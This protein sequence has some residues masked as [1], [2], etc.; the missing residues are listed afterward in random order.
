MRNILFISALLFLGCNSPTKKPIQKKNTTSQIDSTAID[1]LKLTPKTWSLYKIGGHHLGQITD[2][3]TW[4]SEGCWSPDCLFLRSDSIFIYHFSDSY[5]YNIGY[6]G[7]YEITNDS[8]ILNFS[9]LKRYYVWEE[10]PNANATR[11]YVQDSIVNSK[12]LKFKIDTSSN[13][14]Q[15]ITGDT[16]G[17]NVSTFEKEFK[18]LNSVNL[19]LDFKRDKTID[20]IFENSEYSKSEIG[21]F[22]SSPVFTINKKKVFWRIRA[23]GLNNMGDVIKQLIDKS[24]T[25]VILSDTDFTYTRSFGYSNTFKNLKSGFYDVNFDGLLD[26]TD[27]CHSCSGTGGS[28]T[29]VYTYDSISGAFNKSFLSG[30]NFEIDTINYTV[31]TLWK[32][33]RGWRNSTK[34]QFDEVGKYLF[35]ENT[36]IEGKLIDTNYVWITSY[37]KMFNDSIIIE[38]TDTSETDPDLDFYL[39]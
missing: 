2:S 25:K 15:I 37:K 38:K 36:L 34:H 30:G 33:G 11:T 35:S 6:Y 23:T 12:Q 29:M 32:A 18:Y 27:Y 1:T 26:F 20:S 4:Y 39:K 7:E 10:V 21:I 19:Y 3:C 14:K 9:K 13:C 17:I 24:T 28:F 31:S 22:L 16:I 5:D 8:L